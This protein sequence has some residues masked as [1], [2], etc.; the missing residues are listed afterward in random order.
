MSLQDPKIKR[1]I[2]INSLRPWACCQEFSIGCRWSAQKYGSFMAS[3]FLFLGGPRGDRR[4]P[5]FPR[6]SVPF[7][8][9]G[10]AE[11]HVY[12][13][14]RLAGSSCMLREGLVRRTSQQRCHRGPAEHRIGEQPRHS[15]LQSGSGSRFREC[16]G[17]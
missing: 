13:V 17:V 2:A 14:A 5:T 16:E 7:Q 9:V 12:K 3:A 4:I 15:D 6:E 1:S 8:S 11:P 10:S